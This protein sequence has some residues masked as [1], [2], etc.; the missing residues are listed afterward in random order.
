VI[1]NAI[2]RAGFRLRI[3]KNFPIFI[4]AFVLYECSR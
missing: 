1:E 2:R 4:D 3:A